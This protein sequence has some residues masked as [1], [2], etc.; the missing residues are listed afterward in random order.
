MFLTT[1]FPG[2][3]RDR[4]SLFRVLF[5]P[6]GFDNKCGRRHLVLPGPRNFLDVRKTAATFPALVGGSAPTWSMLTRIRLGL[7]F[8]LSRLR[9]NRERN[10]R[11][12]D[13]EQNRQTNQPSV[14]TFRE[15]SVPERHTTP[16][17]LQDVETLQHRL[18]P[19][20]VQVIVAYFNL[21]RGRSK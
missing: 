21:Q 8:F 5:L 6:C 1:M 3:F 4:N 17:R 14:D 2:T 9:A 12:A 10:K 18:T 11:G 7:V 16:Q 15:L 13:S 19:H 20:T